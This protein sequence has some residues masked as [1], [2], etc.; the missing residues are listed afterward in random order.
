ILERGSRL[1]VQG[2]TGGAGLRGIETEEPTPI[3]CSILYFDRSSKQLQAWDEI[4]LGGL[5]EAY[6]TITRHTVDQVELDAA[7]E[8]SED[9]QGHEPGSDLVPSSPPARLVRE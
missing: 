8:Q 5:G 9:P 3:M 7:R 2:S 1:L 6:A 4:T